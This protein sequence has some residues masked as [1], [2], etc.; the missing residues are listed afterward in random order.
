MKNLTEQQLIENY[1]KLVTLV[2]E[3]FTGDRKDNLLA[4]YKFFED[5]MVVAP[6][7]GKPYYHYYCRRWLYRACFTYCRNC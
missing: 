2:E 5:R 7:S 4:M 1:N 6:A 3:N